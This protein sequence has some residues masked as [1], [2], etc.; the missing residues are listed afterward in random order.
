[1]ATLDN[2]APAVEATSAG[3]VPIADNIVKFPPQR[4]LFAY[5][6]NERAVLACRTADE[7]RAVIASWK[8]PG[9]A[10]VEPANDRH[11]RDNN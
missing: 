6:A 10:P 11:W 9:L 2:I 7:L 3:V 4:S 1:M 8:A 5:S